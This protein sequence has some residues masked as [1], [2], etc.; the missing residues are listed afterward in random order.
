MQNFPITNKNV[1]SLGFKNEFLAIQRALNLHL[2]VCKK[3]QDNC[4]ECLIAENIKF[5]QF[6]AMEFPLTPLNTNKTTKK[7]ILTKPP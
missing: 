6:T 2:E 3:S 1:E 4:L 7:L 5:K